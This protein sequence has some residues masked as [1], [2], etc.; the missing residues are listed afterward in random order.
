[1]RSRGIA[2]L[3]YDDG[4]GD[5]AKDDGECDRGECGDDD[6]GDVGG[7]KRG[8]GT[9]VAYRWWGCLWCLCR[10]PLKGTMEVLCSSA[11]PPATDAAGRRIVL[12][13]RARRR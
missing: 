2:R 5:A 6:D 1:M 8:S 4:D 7:E 9:V 3:W 13:R 12:F 10:W 11:V